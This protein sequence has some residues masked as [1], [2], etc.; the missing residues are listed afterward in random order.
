MMFKENNEKQSHLARVERLVAPSI[1]LGGLGACGGGQNSSVVPSAEPDLSVVRIPGS[2]S[3]PYFSDGSSQG[4]VR[5]FYSIDLFGSSADEVI[6]AGFETQP[7]SPADYS[8]TR[9]HIVSVE[10]G[11]LAAKTGAVLSGQQS[12]VQ[13]VGDVVSGDFNGDGL[14]DFFTSAYA[15]MDF[16]VT[17]YEFRSSGDSFVRSSLALDEWQHG[18]AAIDI[19]RDGFVDVYAAGYRGADIYVGSVNGLQKFNVGGDYGGGSAV[20]LGDFLG[21]G[22]VQ[23]VVV[24]SG[25]SL[26]DDTVIFS[27]SV[28]LSGRLV[29]LNEVGRL[30]TPRL[31]G[32]EFSSSLGNVGERSH[33]VRV[34]AFDFNSDGRLDV[35]VLSRGDYDASVGEWPLISQIQ[36]LRN[37]GGGR[38]T[39]VTDSLLP[40]YNEVSYVGYAPVFGDFNKDGRMDIFLS[41][42][43]FSPTHVSSVFLMGDEGGSFREVGRDL[44]SRIIPARGGMATVARDEI[45]DYLLLV[46]E[47]DMKVSG[48]EEV[49]TAYRLDFA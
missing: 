18:A 10:S 20:A 33:D 1:L 21:D 2:L 17:A 19:N 6:V 26:V 48:T 41:D 8:E 46:G 32:A 37:D 31:E 39:D 47:Q 29:I 11:M 7:N 4:V 49:L 14:V 28:D 25:S 16:F 24:D 36:F 15:D 38:F 45:G 42:A 34:E 5:Y 40:N 23:A 9:L 27:L 13:G 44:L 35:V 22:T 12:H 43:D 30:P 3:L